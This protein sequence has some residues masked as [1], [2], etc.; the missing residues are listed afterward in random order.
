MDPFI[1]GGLISG[2]LNVL[3]NIGGS[4]LSS[5]SADK[6]A[7]RNEAFQREFA[8]QGLSWKV[9]DAKKAGINPLVALGA[10]T[11]SPAPS[12]VGTNYGDLGLGQLGQNISRGMTAKMTAEQ[13]ELHEL[14]KRLLEVQIE[15]QAI[16]NNNARNTGSGPP[17]PTAD[18]SATPSQVLRNGVSVVPSEVVASYQPGV[19]GGI[20]PNYQHTSDDYGRVITKPSTSQSEVNESHFPSRMRENLRAASDIAKAFIST[21][22]NTAREVYAKELRSLRPKAAPGYEYRYNLSTMT[23]DPYKLGKDGR[24]Y[25][26]TKPTKHEKFIEKRYRIEGR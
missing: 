19:E 4:L 3:G 25:L 22:S 21:F 5:S 18:Y 12:A 17:L 2:G 14:N 8:K 7:A 20:K 13:R 23:W 26:F 10:S 1:T 24:S 16:D 6:A 11:Y 15:G 9:A